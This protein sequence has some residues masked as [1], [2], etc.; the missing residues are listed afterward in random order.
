MAFCA[1]ASLLLRRAPLLPVPGVRGLH[2]VTLAQ[3]LSDR[4]LL[5]THIA[6]AGWV[7]AER[8][9]KDRTFIDLDDGIR[10][11]TREGG[12]PAGILQTLKRTA[13]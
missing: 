6:V 4:A 10:C 9:Q 13:S 3:A 1:P 5:G 12:T 8:V 7:K 2:R 11:G